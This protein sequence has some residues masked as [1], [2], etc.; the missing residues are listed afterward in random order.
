MIFDV[1]KPADA[2]LSVMTLNEQILDPVHY[3]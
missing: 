1:L 3:L 2:L